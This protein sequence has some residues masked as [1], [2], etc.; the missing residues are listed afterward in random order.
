M[1]KYESKKPKANYYLNKILKKCSTY[2]TDDSY[3]FKIVKEWMIVMQKLETTKTNELRKDVVD[4]R[5]AKFRANELRVIEIFN[6]KDTKSVRKSITNLRDGNKTIYKT[7][8]IIR[9]DKYD[10]NI[11]NVC[12][13][14][15]HYFKTPIAAFYYY[16]TLITELNCTGKWIKFYNNGQKEIEENYEN[17][18][19][20]GELI[21]FYENGQKESEGSFLDGYKTGKWT[22]FFDDGKIASK[23]LYKNGEK[24]GHWEY[25]YENEQKESEGNYMDGK[26]TGYWIEFY[27]NGTIER[28]CEFLNGK[29]IGHYA[30][31]YKN[32][33]KKSEG[34][35]LNDEKS[36]KWNE[37]YENGNKKRECNFYN[38]W[39]DGYCINFYKNGTNKSKGF[40]SNGKKTGFWT[41]WDLFER[42]I[43]KYY[44]NGIETQYSYMNG[45]NIGIACVVF[46]AIFYWNSIVYS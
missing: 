11:E 39:K 7:N 40:Y 20:T 41:E 6:M 9:P 14:G 26:K 35:Y 12:S 30:D 13:G 45:F 4:S 10:E 8:K 46:L 34:K 22:E 19:R 2:S 18:K 25:F 32:S 27:E 36:G 15:I 33:K 17:G 16:P 1:S 42:K 21:E 28:E 5:Y 3:V 44:K 29:R 23:G 38:G 31:Y 37:F 24:F 43:T